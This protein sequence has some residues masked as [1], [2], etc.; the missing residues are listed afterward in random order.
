MKKTLLIFSF[1]LLY[2]V[3]KSQAPIGYYDSAEGLRGDALRMAL[4]DIIKDHNRISYGELW[5]AYEYTD[6][7]SNGKVWEIYSN[8]E[9]TFF[10]DQCGNY[11]NICDCYNREHTVPKS[12]FNDA[13]PMYSDIFHV[14]P[15]DGKVNG[16]R[17][18]HPYGECSGTY[19]GT[20]K[21]GNCTYP[22]YSGTVFEP[23][24]EYKGDVARIYFYMAT[25]YMDVISSWSGESFSGN[26]LSDWTRS[27]MLEWHRNDPVSQKEIDRNDAAYSY[28][29]NRNPFVDNPEYAEAIWNPNYVPSNIVDRAI[30]FEIFPNPAK[31]ILNIVSD[32]QIK[33]LVIRDI[34]GK[35]VICL[36]EFSSHEIVIE[37][38]VSGTYFINFVDI[39]NKVY[40]EK[41]Q[42]IK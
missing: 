1:L 6:M 25:R 2:C 35:D 36:P 39:N 33:S 40:I 7:K 32:V 37:D 13:S 21:L 15:S 11:S 3:S 8:C 18:N 38:L 4:H 14:I 23:V 5:E 12:W 28:Q 29:Y 31:D 41:I 22:G 10:S 9:F 30:S 42:V 20:A 24:D 27:M 16:Y 17:S 34:N 19:Y 26:N